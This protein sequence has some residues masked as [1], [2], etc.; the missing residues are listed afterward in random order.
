MC[1]HLLLVRFQRIKEEDTRVEFF[2]RRSLV[3]LLEVIQNG[4]W[5]DNNAEG[6]VETLVDRD[7]DELLCEDVNLLPSSPR[8]NGLGTTLAESSVEMRCEEMNRTVLQM[9]LLA[10]DPNSQKQQMIQH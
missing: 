10:P 5:V 6:P 4:T 2:V 9:L 8:S 3:K 1:N 7:K